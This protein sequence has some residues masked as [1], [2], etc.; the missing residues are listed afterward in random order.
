MKLGTR[1][2][3]IYLL[4]ISLSLITLGTLVSNMLR[5]HFVYDA[6]KIMTAEAQSIATLLANDEDIDTAELQ[7]S[8]EKISRSIKARITIVT[9]DG[10]VI[11]DSQSKPTKPFSVGNMP[12]VQAAKKE[13][14]GLALRKSEHFKTDMLYVAVPLENTG[15]FR[16]VIRL[17]MPIAEISAEFNDVEEIGALSTVAAAIIAVI[18]GFFFVRS[19]TKPIK[20]MTAMAE[21]IAAGDLT[22]RSGVTGR[23]ELGQLAESL[24]IMADQLDARIKAYETSQKRRQLVIDHITDG[25]IML[26]AHGLIV[27]V[28]PVAQNMLGMKADRL[29]GH[30]LPDVISSKE[31]AA[32]LEQVEQE[33]FAE[34]I[35]VLGRD[36]R[37]VRADV[38]SVKGGEEQESIIIVLH[39]VTR[40]HDLET[41]RRE[42]IINFS[43]ELKTPITGIRLL[44]ETLL[45]A[46]RENREE[47][48]YFAGII[49]DETERL[50][51]F[52]EQMTELAKLDSYEMRSS[53]EA[54]AMETILQEVMS[55]CEPLA[56]E[57]GLE[58]S[59]V[60]D[61]ALPFVEGDHS[62]LRMVFQNLIE[63][64]VKY[65]NEGSVAVNATAEED[66]WV[67]VSVVDTGLGIAEQDLPRVFDRFFRADKAHSRVIGG[68]GL[69][70]SIVKKI[71]DKHGGAVKVESTPGK[72]SIFTVRLPAIETSNKNPSRERVQ[73]V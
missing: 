8:I 3:L 43:H 25:V 27:I 31:L 72:G 44:S 6:G 59:A 39:D 28:N 16:G 33:D 29:I 64:A 17:N 54:I 5:A 11:A 62:Q 50:A 12:E 67:E 9:E 15:K 37:I 24:N 56:R 58:L 34:C 35:L 23:D 70:L 46:V 38:L 14:R 51:S 22:P 48:T 68:T 45:D 52:V 57:K 26:N 42:F 71:V 69:G 41:I 10:M 20:E 32:A 2:T 61:Q 13:G 66:G 63:N 47:A 7:K 73:K 36:E 49:R 60:V 30:P 18:L 65:T 40:E 1:L 21:A 55:L 19:I 4:I 53:F